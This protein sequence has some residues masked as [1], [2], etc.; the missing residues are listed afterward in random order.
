MTI[1]KNDLKRFYE[2]T[3]VCYLDTPIGYPHYIITAWNPFSEKRDLD[4]NREANK[5]LEDKLIRLV[6]Q[7]SQIGR[8][9]G[10]DT[11]GHW[12]EESFWVMGVAKEKILE[13]ARLYEQHA[14][15][16]VHSPQE[17]ELIW[18]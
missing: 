8:C 11:G 1:Q 7:P 16:L 3:V 5:Q 6:N 12:Q 18:A 15:F 13:L 17:R 2:S 9:I 14:V 4:Q 10:S